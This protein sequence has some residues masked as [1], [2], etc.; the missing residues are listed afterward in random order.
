MFF[1]VVLH[2]NLKLKSFQTHGWEQHWIDTAE[3]LVS[4]QY[5]K[6]GG[7][8]VSDAGLP[9]PTP[10]QED[11]TDFLDIPL[12]SLDE[13]SEID[14]Y[15]AL[16]LEKVQDPI[17][18][19]WEHKALYPTL[20]AMALDYLSAPATS[21]AVE[22]LFSQ[23]CQLLHFTHSHPSPSM[24]HAFLCFGDWSQKDLVDMPDLAVAIHQLCGHKRSHSDVESVG[25]S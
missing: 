7:P 13:Q 1:F 9:L 22:R 24:I 5:Q 14:N 16:P 15:F 2:P 8:L 25:S 20:S 11:F 19:W 23:G 3:A 17:A 12:E 18:W 21:T 10:D 6:Y 4:E